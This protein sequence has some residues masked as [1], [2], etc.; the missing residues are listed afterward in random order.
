MTNR[1]KSSHQRKWYKKYGG[2]TKDPDATIECIEC[3]NTLIGDSRVISIV[4]LDCWM[5]K[6]DPLQRLLD[7]AKYAGFDRSQADTLRKTA[8]DTG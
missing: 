4:C 7:E 3:G 5:K 1:G 8:E 2:M 6:E